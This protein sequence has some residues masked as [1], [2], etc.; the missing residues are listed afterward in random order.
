RRPVV[1][2]RRAH[3]VV[4]VLADGA[5]TYLV[6]QPAG[7]QGGHAVGRQRLERAGLEE[8]QVAAD[9]VGSTGLLGL[10]R[11]EEDPA[12]GGAVAHLVV[13]TEGAAPRG[14]ALPDPELADL[15]GAQRRPGGPT[16]EVGD[17]D[18]PR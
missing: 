12:V 9:P 18:H 13:L 5:A 8:D 4:V 6:R 11:G 14:G 16:G 15:R 7:A 2:G 17:L 1:M 10:G 3:G